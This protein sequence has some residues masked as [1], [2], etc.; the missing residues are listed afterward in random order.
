M[1]TYVNAAIEIT[2][3]RTNLPTYYLNALLQHIKDVV[4]NELNTAPDDVVDSYGTVA[5]R[6]QILKEDE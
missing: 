5:V 4:E 3:L 1:E 6:T 2:C